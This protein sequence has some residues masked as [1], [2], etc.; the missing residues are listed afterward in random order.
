VV[1]D[2]SRVIGR[3]EANQASVKDTL[4]RT[5][6]DVRAAFEKSQQEGRESRERLY[7][8]IEATNANIVELKTAL[9]T[10]NAK[11]SK[12]EDGL[13]LLE[14]WR[15]QM[16]GAKMAVWAMAALLGATVATFGKWALAKIGQ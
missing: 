16:V 12:L 7:R 9:A 15:Q 10:T 5:Q 13:S 8:E 3:I 14:K 4:E 11:L 6:A 1:D 2:L